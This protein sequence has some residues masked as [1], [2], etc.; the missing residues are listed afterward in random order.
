VDPDLV[1]FQILGVDIE[2]NVKVVE[3][4]GVLGNTIDSKVARPR[5][6]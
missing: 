4:S 3:S 5:K 6:I 1:Q 2:D